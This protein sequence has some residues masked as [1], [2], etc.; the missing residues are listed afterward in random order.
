MKG[1]IIVFIFI[2]CYATASH[3][4]FAPQAGVAGTTAIHKDSNIFINWA[5]GCTLIRGWQNIEDTTLG[6]A[7][8]GDETYVPGSPANGIVSLGDG[9]IAI[10][11]FE[12]PIQNGPGYDFAVFENGF[13]DQTLKPGTAFLELAFVEVS[14]DGIHYYRFPSIS[15]TDTVNQIASFEGIDASKLNN[16]AGKYINNFGTPF[17]LDDLF[18]YDSLDIQRITHVKIIDVVGSIH[19]AFGSADS[20][21]HIINDPW[22]TPFPSSG[23]DLDGIGV[24]HQRNEIGMSEQVKKMDLKIFPIPAKSGQSIQLI[25]EDNISKKVSVINSLGQIEVSLQ[26]DNQ[27]EKISIDKPGTYLL[28]IECHSGIYHYKFWV[29]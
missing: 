15:N 14:S 3:A 18:G 1:S 11:T 9:G 10:V 13:I 29:D 23:F 22:P 24:I 12:K 17:N 4:Q 21:G 16:L 2:I 27:T 28:M 26:T 25:F 7:L 19:K 5:T 6:K 8:V 20:R